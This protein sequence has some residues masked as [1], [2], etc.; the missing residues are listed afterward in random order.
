MSKKKYNSLVATALNQISVIPVNE[1][2]IYSWASFHHVA[3]EVFRWMIKHILLMS[4]CGSNKTTLLPVKTPPQRDLWHQNKKKGVFLSRLQ[5]SVEWIYSIQSPEYGTHSK[6]YSTSFIIHLTFF[7][8]PKGKDRINSC[9]LILAWSR[10]MSVTS[11]W[12]EGR[13]MVSWF[14]YPLT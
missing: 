14:S 8:Y 10:V 12:Q 5:R 3:L 1:W 11:V 9:C 13:G 4:M 2:S 7:I 6:C